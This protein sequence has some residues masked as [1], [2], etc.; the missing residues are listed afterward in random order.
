[1]AGGF[2]AAGRRWMC[3]LGRSGRAGFP[4]SFLGGEKVR[5]CCAARRR[6]ATPG[7]PLIAGAEMSAGARPERSSP[8]SAVGWGPLPFAVQGP[9]CLIQAVFNFLLL[10]L[11]LWTAVRAAAG[12][13]ELIGETMLL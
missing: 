9:V 10:V 5:S 3:G 7:V 4:V 13:V 2:V 8:R 6:L 1:M 11:G 12:T